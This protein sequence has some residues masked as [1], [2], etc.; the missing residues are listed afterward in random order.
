MWIN[1]LDVIIRLSMGIDAKKIHMIQFRYEI[2]GKNLI[3]Q[4]SHVQRMTWTIHMKRS[5]MWTNHVEIC[6]QGAVVEGVIRL[7]DMDEC[8]ISANR[9]C[10]E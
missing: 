10:M 3:P 2:F 4:L 7:G 6:V 9:L 8:P 5:V 1:Y